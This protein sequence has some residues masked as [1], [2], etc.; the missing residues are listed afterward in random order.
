MSLNHCQKKP[1]LRY[2]KIFSVD[3]IG[4]LKMIKNVHW[5]SFLI[6]LFRVRMNDYY[7]AKKCFY[8]LYGNLNET[9]FLFKSA[10]KLGR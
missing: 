4:Q 8:T 3:I 1:K 2:V 7:S 5:N 9:K 10:R 6:T